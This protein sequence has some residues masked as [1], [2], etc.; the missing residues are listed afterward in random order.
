MGHNE[1]PGIVPRFCEELFGRVTNT[2]DD[3][4]TI[5]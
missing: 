1:E 2:A 5:T 4:V 3:M